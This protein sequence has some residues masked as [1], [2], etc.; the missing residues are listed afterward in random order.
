MVGSSWE[1]FGALLTCLRAALGHFWPL[2]GLLGPLGGLLGRP[3]GV[4]EASWKNIEKMSNGTCFLEAMLASKMDAKINKNRI[5]KA[6]H[7]LT[8]FFVDFL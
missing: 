7:V 3:W 8:C 6:M 4:L 2:L 5:Q 1:A